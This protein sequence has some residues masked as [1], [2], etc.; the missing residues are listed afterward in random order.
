MGAPPTRR[1]PGRPPT[2]LDLP[3][4]AAE[5]GVSEDQM[6][7]AIA[8]ALAKRAASA[9]VSSVTDDGAGEQVPGS[10]PDEK[11]GV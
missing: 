11:K 10:S 2:Q 1:K 8:R 4:L 6:A 9:K 5:V 3:A 7:M